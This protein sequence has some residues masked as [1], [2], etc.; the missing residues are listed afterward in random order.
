MYWLLF[1]PMESFTGC[2]ISYVKSYNS[3]TIDG[4]PNGPGPEAQQVRG[5]SMA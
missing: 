5:Q 1:S 4:L 2:S 3:M